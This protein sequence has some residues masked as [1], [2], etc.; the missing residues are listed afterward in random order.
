MIQ[1]FQVKPQKKSSNKWVCMVCSQR[2]S[3]LCIYI[4]GYH[5]TDLRRFVR[6]ANLARGRWDLMPEPEEECG[7]MTTAEEQ[8]QDE[9]P[10]DKKWM[11]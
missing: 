7:P 10:R 4:W 11:G 2:Q 3:V 8:Q 5:A 6:E 1:W 9:F